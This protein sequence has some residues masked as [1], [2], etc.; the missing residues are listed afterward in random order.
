MSTSLVQRRPR[1]RPSSMLKTQLSSLGFSYGVF[2]RKIHVKNY[3]ALNDFGL[4]SFLAPM[5]GE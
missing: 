4:E 3:D 1:E 5:I 2:E